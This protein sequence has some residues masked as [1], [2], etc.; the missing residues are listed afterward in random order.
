MIVLHEIVRDAALA[1]FRRMKGL[2][3]EAALVAMDVGLDQDDTGQDCGNELQKSPLE[4][5]AV[6]AHGE[7][8]AR[9]LRVFLQLDAQRADE[10]VDRSRRAL[11]LRSP[12]A[13]KD[14][15]AAQSAP[16]GLQEEAQYLELLR[17][18]LDRLALALDGLPIEVHFHRAE[19]RDRRFLHGRR[20]AAEQ[21][22]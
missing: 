14:V 6:P 5:V 13:R 10:V 3:K 18:D 4:S 12:A 21:R 1:V 2:E 9:L 16:T 8:V 22:L 15:L 17:A 19:A 7:E 11:V 20:P